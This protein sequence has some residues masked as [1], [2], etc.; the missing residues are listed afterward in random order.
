MRALAALDIKDVEATR[1]MHTQGKIEAKH[2]SPTMWE[3]F[4]A[5][6]ALMAEA[7]EDDGAEPD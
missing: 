3:K 7:D 1:V 5:H 4:A 6:D 2:I